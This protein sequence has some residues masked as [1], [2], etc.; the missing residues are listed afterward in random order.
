MIFFLQKRRST[1]LIIVALIIAISVISLA[2]YQTASAVP[3]LPFGGLVFNVIWCTCSV[4]A[5]VQ[6]GPPVG[7]SFWV[8]PSTV[9]FPFFRIPSPGVWLLGDY[10]PGGACLIFVGK[11]CVP[12]PV[13][14]TIL[15]VG[16]SQ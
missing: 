8:N 10:T 14:G 4:G 1:L 13:T 3:G 15:F 11:E 7:G 9:V 6:V 12:V 5:V 2:N 16:T